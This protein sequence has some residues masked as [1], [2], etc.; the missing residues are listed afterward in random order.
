MRL[1]FSPSCLC[2]YTQDVRDDYVLYLSCEAG[3]KEG[4]C[5]RKSFGW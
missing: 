3:K 1:F 5:G 2:M 4:V